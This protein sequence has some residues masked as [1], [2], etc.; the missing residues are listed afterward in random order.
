V[1]QVPEL[2]QPPQGWLLL[3]QPQVLAQPLLPQPPLQRPPQ[4][5]GWAPLFLLQ[6][7]HLWPQEHKPH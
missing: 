3:P 1:P 2:A 5:L 4:L 7:K 6:Q